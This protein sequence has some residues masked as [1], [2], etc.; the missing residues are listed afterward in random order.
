MSNKVY[1]LGRLSVI[2]TRVTTSGCSGC[3]FH[4]MIRDCGY[5]EDKL[6]SCF[7]TGIKKNTITL[8][9]FKKVSSNVLKMAK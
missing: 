8:Y 5:Y 4:T 1:K 6:P 9:H 2:R 3:Y 7:V